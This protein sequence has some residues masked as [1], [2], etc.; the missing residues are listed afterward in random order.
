M[1]PTI[2]RGGYRLVEYGDDVTLKI[3]TE[4]PHLLKEGTGFEESTPI[5]DLADGA[6]G[7]AGKDARINVRSTD[8]TDSVY[9]AL[10]TAE[11]NLSKKF[12]RFY[13]LAD[14]V[15]VED[16]EDAWNEFVG[17]DV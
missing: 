9:A 17:A 14:E 16:C 3:A 11:Q 10:V 7:P 1:P 5:E 2:W 15:I 8:L 12:F 6:E 13:V 4:I